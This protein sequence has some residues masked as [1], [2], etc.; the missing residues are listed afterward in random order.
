MFEGISALLIG[1]ATGG[2]GLVEVDETKERAGEK[3][4][5]VILDERFERC[6]A[7]R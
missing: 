5:P 7:E 1:S 6:G 3:T 4:L 2:I